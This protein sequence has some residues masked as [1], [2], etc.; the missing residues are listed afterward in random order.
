MTDSDCIIV[1]A[2]CAG[3]ALAVHLARAGMRVLVFEADQLHADQPFSTHAIQSRGMDLLD[4]LGVG[5][6]LRAVTPMVRCTRLEVSGQVLDVPLLAGRGMYCPR[7]STLDPLLQDAAIQ[8]GAELRTETRVRELLRAGDRV[9][10]V[11]TERAGKVEEHRA[12]WVIGADG[13]NSSVARMVGARSY[14]EHVSERGGYWG[15]WQKPDCWD[16]DEPWRRFQTVISLDTTARFVFECDGGLLIMGAVPA[17][18]EARAWGKNYPEELRKSLW[19]SPLTAA[20]CEAEPVAPLVGLLKTRYFVREP[21]GPGWALVG[22]AGVHKDATPGHGITDALRDAAALAVALLDGSDEALEVFWR[23]RDVDAL[24]LYF[25]ALNLG[26]LSFANPFN[27]LVMDRVGRD[28]GLLR[29]MQEVLDR[30]RSPFELVPPARVL[31]WV[32]ETL[33]R[34]QFD[35]LSPFLA[36]ARFSGHVQREQKQRERLLAQARKRFARSQR[37]AVV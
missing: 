24:P 26:S 28:A 3:A 8:A 23:A 9:C 17:M 14:I 22:D 20:L 13:R 34:G 16:R 4:E 7:R 18:A 6:Q 1:G 12:R 32:A 5:A 11:R 25:Q 29:R 2:R 36:S 19:G 37:Q 27:A 15:Y 21:V 10:G 33:W 31:A 35:V 30:E